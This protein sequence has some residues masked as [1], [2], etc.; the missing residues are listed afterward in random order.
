MRDLAARLRAIVKT[1]VRP[2]GL[3]SPESRE[4]D[5]RIRYVADLS[6]PPA[7]G[8]RV[9]ELLGGVLDGPSCVVIDRTWDAYQSHGRQRVESYAVAA[10]APIALFD[11]R[12]AVEADWA[13]RIVFF[14]VETTGLSG[15]A[16]TL[17]FLAGCGWFEHGGFRVR[18]F[19]L[20][21]AAGEHA[22]LDALAAIFDA[23][24]LLVTFN[25]RSFDVPLMETRWAFHR[26]D[27][28]TG[29]LPHFDMLP[30]ARLLWSRRE[31]DRTSCTLSALERSVLRFHRCDDVPGFEIPS[32]YFHFLRTGDTS[33]I[34]G[35]IEHNQHD[36]ISLAAILAH[37][38]RL[39]S[40]GADACETAGEQ[41]GLGRLYERAG[42]RPRALHSYEL[43]AAA[44]DREVGSHALARL[45][46][47][48]R[49]EARHDESAAV[50][51]RVLE[52][53]PRERPPT[54]LARRAAEALAIYH[55][56]RARDLSTAKRYAQSLR[57][58]AG[59][60][61]GLVEKADHRL[62][63]LDRK[64]RVDKTKGGLLE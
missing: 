18:Q 53:A 35:V 31:D 39:A 27:C 56:H 23:A 20:S 8:A 24:S 15:G 60:R 37:A 49:R 17:A 58:A 38:L 62:G 11:P 51:R 64:M 55:E 5:P 2:R 13:S 59:G 22:M 33:A 47:L 48:L 9:A 16:G 52:C 7:D 41:L 30:P 61:V 50:W 19:L 54:A 25:G 10:G 29:G 3:S 40:D 45:A 14:D 57:A 4:N 43:A 36:L 44:G 26:R 42:D 12:A 28:P 34:R 63:R 32:R 46:L 1:D 21:G 6:A